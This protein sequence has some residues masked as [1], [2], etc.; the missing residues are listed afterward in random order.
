MKFQGIHPLGHQVVSMLF[1]ILF[2][3]D[4]EDLGPADIDQRLAHSPRK[5]R[6]L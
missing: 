4:G 2:D 6:E 1:S 3:A 5:W